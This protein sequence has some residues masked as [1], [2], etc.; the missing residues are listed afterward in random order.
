MSQQIFES[1]D[2]C[3]SS[4][5]YQDYLLKHFYHFGRHW[6]HISR[7]GCQQTEHSEIFLWSNPKECEKDGEYFQDKTHLLGL[8]Y[9]DVY[10]AYWI[11]VVLSYES[12]VMTTPLT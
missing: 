12:G 9:A 6:W 1:G 4:G 5:Y 11:G 7:N 2:L 8:V 3:H 10:I